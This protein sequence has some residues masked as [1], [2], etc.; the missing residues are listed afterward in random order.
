MSDLY[1]T[2]ETYPSA[3]DNQVSPHAK[4]KEAAFKWSNA[5][6]RETDNQSWM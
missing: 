5:N 2:N 3:S 6:T 1:I 4:Q